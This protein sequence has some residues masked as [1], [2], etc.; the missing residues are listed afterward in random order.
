[1]RS[2]GVAVDDV[3]YSVVGSQL[4]GS[5]FTLAGTKIPDA[6]GQ[7]YDSL[8]IKF[9]PDLATVKYALLTEG[10]PDDAG[11]ASGV[12]HAAIATNPMTGQSVVVGFLGGTT[13]LGVGKMVTRNGGLYA[14]RRQH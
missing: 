10:Q 13:D 14:I 9:S 3:G 5:G 11:N 6:L 1:M 7:D 4:S 8:V 12:R 2:A